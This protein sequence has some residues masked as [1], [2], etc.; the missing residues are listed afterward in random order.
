[1]FHHG[2]LRG[3]SFP[4]IVCYIGM[5]CRQYT[6]VDEISVECDAGKP[7]AAVAK[8][9]STV[10]VGDV[11]GAEGGDGAG[12]GFLESVVGGKEAGFSFSA[13]DAGDEG[14]LDFGEDVVGGRWW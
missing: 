14:V 7:A 10:E 13:M 2:L 1:M 5:V 8:P 12:A 4:A 6:N 9:L 3:F 11:F